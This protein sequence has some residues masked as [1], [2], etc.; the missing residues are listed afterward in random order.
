ME[1]NRPNFKLTNHCK[2]VIS[3]LEN[4]SNLTTKEIHVMLLNQKSF[5]GKN[6]RRNPTKGQLAQILNK[7]PYFE[8]VG[9]TVKHTVSRPNVKVAVWKLSGVER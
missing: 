7:Y 3:I 2:R 6:Y 9:T 5:T 1:D 8:R 4:K